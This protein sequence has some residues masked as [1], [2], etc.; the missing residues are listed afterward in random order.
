MGQQLKQL[1]TQLYKVKH[2]S[3]ACNQDSEGERGRSVKLGTK[4]CKVWLAILIGQSAFI[5]Q[6]QLSVQASPI[7]KVLGLG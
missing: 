5:N 3:H 7:H 4:L 2:P 1:Y 6:G